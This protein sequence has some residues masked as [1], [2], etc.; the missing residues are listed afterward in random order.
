MPDTTD[1]S[2]LGVTARIVA[3][4][5]EN[6]HIATDALPDL[7]RRVYRSLVLAGAPE[8]EQTKLLIPAVPVKRSVFPAF[9]VCLEDGKKLKTL[10]RHLKTSFNL[11]PAEY[12]TKWGL[13]H[14][15]PMVAPDY[16]VVRSGLAKSIGLGRRPT[17]KAGEFET[18]EAKLPEITLVPARRARGSGA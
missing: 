7:I 10:K 14:D 5:V 15:Y 18:T 13:P 11:S 17:I 4:H 12:R 8:I 2:M 1:G 9:I 3:A 16:A 6:N